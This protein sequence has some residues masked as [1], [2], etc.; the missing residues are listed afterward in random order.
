MGATLTDSGE[1]KATLRATDAQVAQAASV[2]EAQLVNALPPELAHLVQ[3]ALGIIARGGTVTIGSIPSELTTTTAADML[4]ISRPT[5]MKL[6]KDGALPS[7]KVGSH[8]RLRASEVVAY[9]EAQREQRLA[10]LA[11]LRAY[12]DDLG[13][14]Y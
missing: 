10:A 13:R 8:T 14:T 5:L 11:D 6:I 12:E 3:I 7:Y 2:D 9:R 4:D 1:A